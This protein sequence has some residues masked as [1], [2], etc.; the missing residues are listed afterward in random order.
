MWQAA[1][2]IRLRGATLTVHVGGAVD[3]AAAGTATLAGAVIL[4]ADTLR[5]IGMGVL[6]GGAGLRL[7]RRH[8][9]LVEWQY[10][11]DPLAPP[12]TLGIPAGVQITEAAGLLSAG[13]GRLAVVA[14]AGGGRGLQWTAPGGAAGD[15]IPADADGEIRVDDGAQP[16]HWLRCTLTAARLAAGDAAAVQ[17]A[18]SGPSALDPGDVAAAAAAAGS[19]ETRELTLVNR[20]AAL[21]L[22]NLTV[23]L[24]PGT[25]FCEVSLDNVTYSAAE[26]ETAALAALGA[27]TL[28]AGG[29]IAVYVR[30]TIPAGTAANPSEPLEIR[31]GWDDGTGARALSA[32][33]GV[34]PI[35]NTPEY[36]LYRKLNEPPEPGIDAV[37]ATSAS[38]PVTPPD[39]FADGVWYVGLTWFDGYLESPIAVQ[40]IEIDSGTEVAPRPSAPDNTWMTQTAGGVVLVE[41][42]YAAGPD[43]AVGSAADSFALWYTVDGSAP[44]PTQPA[45]ATQPVGPGPTAAAQFSLGALADATV[46][47]ALVRMRRGAVDSDNTDETHYTVAILAP[48]ASD[49]GQLLATSGAPQ[50]GS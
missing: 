34:Y 43:Q 10:D 19:V 33:R 30:R 40:R 42:L 8:G 9:A 49:S 13:V 26:D 35:E 45:D 46:V 32:A 24:A 7:P 14:R 17:I 28:P 39:V 2:T 3:W 12:A 21:D 22:E 38:L 37:W 11:G 5:P 50:K 29:S 23:W 6:A 41:A 16:D 25:R 31:A 1:G 20:S 47:R 48:D 36:R 15:V 44:D 18:S 4:V 27:T